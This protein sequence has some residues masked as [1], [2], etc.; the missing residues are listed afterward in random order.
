MRDLNTVGLKSVAET[1]RDVKMES[2]RSSYGR[3]RSYGTQG[4]IVYGRLGAGNRAKLW[5]F[6]HK[7]LTLTLTLTR[8]GFGGYN[9]RYLPPLFLL[10]YAIAS[11]GVLSVRSIRNSQLT[12]FIAL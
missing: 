3:A 12:Q 7:P 8:N 4:S 9:I 10:L 11:S 2:P 1:K 5:K 6:L